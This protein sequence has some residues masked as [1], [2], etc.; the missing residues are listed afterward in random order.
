MAV[1]KWTALVTAM[2]GKLRGSVLQFGAAGQVMRSTK[3][4]NQYSNTR[5]NASKTNIA[6]VTQNW[7]NLTS[8]QRSA[9]AAQTVN[10]PEKDR[11]GNTH[12]P[13]P[14]TLHMRLNNAM[15]FHNGT[16]LATPLG[17]ASFTNISPIAVTVGAGPTLTLG[18]NVVTSSNEVILIRATSALSNGRRPPKGLYTLVAS[19]IMSAVTSYDFTSA[20]I[21]RFGSIPTGGQIYFSIAIFNIT[22]GQISTPI[23]TNA[24]T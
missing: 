1:V 8:A 21:A 6:A 15:L 2:K 11:Y 24:F 4:F 23:I 10:Y 16:L 14:Y 19:P 13:S 17:P 12:Y 7:K 22:T 5:W 20:Y 18:I 9:W 3:Q